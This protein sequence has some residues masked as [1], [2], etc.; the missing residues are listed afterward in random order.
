M[1]LK[2]TNNITKEEYTQEVIDEGKSSLF[3]TFT[4]TLP[5]INDGE[6]TY[7]LYDETQKIASGLCQVGEY[8]NQKKT[9]QNN[10]N[11]TV[12]YNV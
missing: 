8:V 7:E 5:N 3:Y 11:K 6:Y 4:L 2:L 12:I 9:Y 10:A 1:I